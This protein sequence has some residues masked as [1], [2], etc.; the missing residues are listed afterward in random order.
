MYGNA[1]ECFDTGTSEIWQDFMFSVEVPSI[2]FKL[3]NNFVLV[4]ANEYV[5]DDINMHQTKLKVDN[6]FSPYK[7]IVRTGVVTGLPEKLESWKENPDSG[8]MWET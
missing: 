4:E 7:Y 5:S 1:E 2:N 6:T 8:L 3:F